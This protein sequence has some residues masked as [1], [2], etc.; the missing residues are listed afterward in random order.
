MGA[1]CVVTV[2][3]LAQSGDYQ[4]RR[5]SKKGEKVEK[6]GQHGEAIYAGPRCGGVP[7]CLP[8]GVAGYEAG[9]CRW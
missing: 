7:G 6:S 5:T 2:R 1:V 9:G 3:P 4:Q 8:A